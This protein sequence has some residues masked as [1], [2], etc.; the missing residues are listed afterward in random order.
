VEANRQ[1][2]N[3]MHFAIKYECLEAIKILCNNKEP[4][5]EDGLKSLDAITYENAF[6][7]FHFACMLENTEI[8][9]YIIQ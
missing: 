9:E 7:P 2:N 6:T 1:G 4:W 8:L 5:Y 3:A